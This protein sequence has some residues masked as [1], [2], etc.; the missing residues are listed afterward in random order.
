MRYCFIKTDNDHSQRLQLPGVQGPQR[1]LKVQDRFVVVGEI[2]GLVVPVRIGVS[3]GV[4]DVGEGSNSSEERSWG[5]LPS[6]E[7]A[8]SFSFSEHQ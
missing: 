4:E 2:V 5:S 1:Y 7:M 6:V 3:S 8:G